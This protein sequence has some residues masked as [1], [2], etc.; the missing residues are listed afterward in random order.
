MGN[1]EGQLVNPSSSFS[2]DGPMITSFVCNDV[3]PCK[4][5]WAI[6][7]KHPYGRRMREAMRR[8]N[9][10]ESD[11]DTD[12]E[13]AYTD[14]NT[15]LQ[16]QYKELG[17]N[18]VQG[19]SDNP[20]INFF[21]DGR[22]TNLC[23]GLIV[24]WHLAF[25]HHYTVRMSPDDILMNIINQIAIHVSLNPEKYRGIFVDHDG[26]KQININSDD[27]KEKNWGKIL[28][29]FCD[30]IQKSVH[31]DVFENILA[32]FSTTTPLRNIIS[33]VGL[34][35][36]VQ[37]YFEY[38]VD[39]ACGVPKVELEGDLEDW[40]KLLKKVD[41]LLSKFDDLDHWRQRLIPTLEKF[42]ETVDP[43]KE[44]DIKWWQSFYHF[45][46]GSGH[47][48]R[49]NGHILS[50]FTYVKRRGKFKMIGEPSSSYKRDEGYGPSSLPAVLSKVPL[51]IHG[52]DHYLM[53]GSIGAMQD[54]TTLTVSPHLM[55]GVYKHQEVKKKSERYYY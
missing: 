12:H 6:R 39:T 37:E 53:A 8:C 40:I 4:E 25:A 51:K 55:W 24:S 32:D 15:V 41:S 36:T 43:E 50:L 20:L 22:S 52:T 9:D 42:I 27:V 3:E 1:V 21:F 35:N 38:C 45:K 54:L 14:I 30:Q 46:S 44:I 18:L 47:P 34:M 33:Q 28:K 13:K 23:N 29:D 2:K 7:M 16:E 49:V 11:D 5:R 17:E 31:E 26:K 19:T 10:Y 48:D